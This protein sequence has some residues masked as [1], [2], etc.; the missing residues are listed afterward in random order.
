MTN[1]ANVEIGFSGYHYT[2]NKGLIRCFR[3]SWELNVLEIGFNTGKLVWFYD[4]SQKIYSPLSISDN[5]DS[6]FQKN[7]SGRFKNEEYL[8]ELP[9]E[10]LL[11]NTICLNRLIT[12]YQVGAYEKL[13]RL[14]DRIIKKKTDE[15]F[16]EH[17]HFSMENEYKA[18]A[19]C[20]LDR[21]SEVIP[22]LENDTGIYVS[23]LKLYS[24][25]K[26]D[27]LDQ[28]IKLIR[29]LTKSRGKE[30][31]YIG[32]IEFTEVHQLFVEMAIISSLKRHLTDDE[33]E[34]IENIIT[35]KQVSSQNQNFIQLVSEQSEKLTLQLDVDELEKIYQSSIKIE[36]VPSRN[37]S[38]EESREFVHKLNLAN[39]NDWKKYCVSGEKPDNIPINPKKDYPFEWKGWNDWLGTTERKYLPYEEAR[40]FV[41]NLTLENENEW[42]LFCKS[43]K[44]PENIPP[45]PKNVYTSDWKDYTDWLGLYDREYL[46]FEQAKEIV[47]K[48]IFEY[49]SEWKEY[50][51]SGQKPKNIPAKPN[52]IYQ[53]QWINWDDWFGIFK[54]EYL[55]Y[56]EQKKFVSVLN[57]DSSSEWTEYA[58]SGQRPKN[59]PA[60]PFKYFEKIGKDPFDIY[61]WLGVN[62]RQYLPFHEA[63]AHVRNLKLKNNDQFR[64][65][66][67]SVRPKNIPRNPSYVY[68]EKGWQGYEDWTGISR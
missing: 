9:D 40:Q 12:Y 60:K 43:G 29:K 20:R 47:S 13:I 31:L 6:Y 39:E 21:F 10:L 61:D 58:K 14:C 27:R 37:I 22:L 24:L 42:K 64:E 3:Y 1:K 57:F 8:E 15:G 56:E 45:N 19:L 36:T 48:L 50:C 53:K 54:R 5:P 34:I 52:V 2:S 59:I 30:G 68:R 49:Q 25:L 32:K 23:H 4:V 18:K 51:T 35:K 46:S 62:E 16:Q 66:N 65:W 17:S 28:A 55:S 7:I 44:L 33:K 67:D 26:M 41:S 11:R 38:F 63:R